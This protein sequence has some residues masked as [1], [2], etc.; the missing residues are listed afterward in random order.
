M[1]GEGGLVGEDGSWTVCTMDGIL[2]CDDKMFDVNSI[3]VLDCFIWVKSRVEVMTLH[4]SLNF[5]NG[6][7]APR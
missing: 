4:R 2:K 6:D 7:D 3:A 5:K 1:C